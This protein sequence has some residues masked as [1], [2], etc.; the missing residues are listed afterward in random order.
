MGKKRRLFQPYP[1][2]GKKTSWPRITL[3]SSPFA[4]TR[5]TRDLYKIDQFHSCILRDNTVNDNNQIKIMALE[6]IFQF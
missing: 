6:I 1:S 4:M 3:A 5:R 2:R